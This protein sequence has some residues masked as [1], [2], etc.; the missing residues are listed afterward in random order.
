MG[1]GGEGRGVRSSKDITNS[2]VQ[3]SACLRRF[4]FGGPRPWRSASPMSGSESSAGETMR[5]SNGE[6]ADA[7]MLILIPKPERCPG[8][9]GGGP[10]SS[11]RYTRR[12]SY[13]DGW[14]GL[15]GTPVADGC[16]CAGGRAWDWV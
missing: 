11:P 12:S 16:V 5:V 10:R 1:G 8:T 6:G 15:G 2:P 7:L 4:F 14:Y 13:D 3:L 9:G